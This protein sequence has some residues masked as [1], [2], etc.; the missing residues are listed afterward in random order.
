MA[1]EKVVETSVLM[2][3]KHYDELGLNPAFKSSDGRDWRGQVH[4]GLRMEW[5]WFK[6]EQEAIDWCGGYCHP[7]ELKKEGGDNGLDY[8]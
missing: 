1:F 4:I 7:L 3:V 2:Q 6:T 5:M 8:R